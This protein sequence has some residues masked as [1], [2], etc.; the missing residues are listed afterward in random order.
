M[1]RKAIRNTKSQ[2]QVPERLFDLVY[3]NNEIY[4]EMKRNKEII[5]VPWDDVE[6]QVEIFKNENNRNYHNQS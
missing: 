1:E 6:T 2:K 4:L 5:C 3:V